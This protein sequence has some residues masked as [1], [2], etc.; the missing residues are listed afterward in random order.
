MSRRPRLAAESLAALAAL[1][2]GAVLFA[3][4]RQ[5]RSDSIFSV[6]DTSKTLAPTAAFFVTGFVLRARRPGNRVG[7]ICFLVGSLIMVKVLW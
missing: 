3:L 6:W 4:N 5:V 2:G 1:A 7:G